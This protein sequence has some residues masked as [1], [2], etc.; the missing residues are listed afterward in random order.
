MKI[1]SGRA[2]PLGAPQTAKKPDGS[3]IRPYQLIILAIPLVLASCAAPDR[4]HHIVV[5]T[6]DQKLALLDGGKVTAV[7]PVSTSKFGLGDWPG[8][9]CT[10]LGELEVAQKIGH[11]APVGMVFKDRRGTGEI[12]WADAP[13]RDPIVT[14]ILWLRGREAQNANAFR[15]R[16]HLHTA[17]L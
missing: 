4:Q 8:S 2:R 3:A 15:R 7:Y 14:R 11:G 12:V 10:P 13:L 5:S 1:D 6:A 9:Y 17:L 16:G